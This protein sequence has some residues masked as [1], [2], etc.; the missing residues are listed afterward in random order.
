MGRKIRNYQ[1]KAYYEEIINNYFT[2]HRDEVIQQ[3]V[4]DLGFDTFEELQ[5]AEYSM[6]FGFDCGFTKLY[7]K[8]PEMRREWVLDEGGR[9]GQDFYAEL[10]PRFA[11]NCQSLTCKRPQVK[12]MLRDLNFEGLFGI[13]ERLD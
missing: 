2:E 12:K 1:P 3:T 11:W 5:K 4:E 6:Y 7:P 9:K 8:N 10:Y 13:T